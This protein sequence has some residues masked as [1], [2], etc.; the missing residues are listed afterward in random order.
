[1]K[2]RRERIG[3][4]HADRWQGARKE[5]PSRDA[6][7]RNRVVV[8]VQVEQVEHRGRPEEAVVAAAELRRDQR[9]NVLLVVLHPPRAEEAA[10]HVED[11]QLLHD[12]EDQPRIARPARDQRVS[13]PQRLSAKSA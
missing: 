10:G 11:Q 12:V 2:V 9:L 13:L 3:I 1:M 8:L 4:E 5:G 6:A 7:A